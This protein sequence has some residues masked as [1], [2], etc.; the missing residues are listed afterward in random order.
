MSLTAAP[1]A[2]GVAGAS[3][4]RPV[5]VIT[6]GCGGIGSATSRVFASRGYSVAMLDV[7]GLRDAGAALESEL[8]SGPGCARFFA[9]DVAS[10]ASV[11]AAFGGV[12]GWRGRIDA[13]VC[14]ATVFIYG[15]VHLVSGDDWDRV[16]SVN[17]KGTA[18]C[19]RAVIPAMRA[20]G[21]GGA[22]VLVS[23]I[24]AATAFPA[25]V[26]YSATKAALVQM[27][28][29]MALDNG[30]HGIRVNCCAPGPFFTQGG[31]VAHAKREGR[32]VEE[33]CAE[34]ARD[35]ALRR[36]GAPDECA[37]SIFFL[38]SPDASFVTGTT[39]HVDGGFFRK[40]TP[41]AM[42]PATPPPP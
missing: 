29:D 26:P 2:A 23:S 37:R 41:P 30:A 32:P 11:A 31:T 6:G 10:E 13:L 12:L 35:V 27:A 19:C 17:I 42:A 5:V 39:L 16:L 15:E 40:D 36:M 8:S 7:E 4:E 28:R 20:S 3:S 21:R 9:V 22:I 14:M 33:L 1:A 18:L 25:F 34:L 38:C 24:T